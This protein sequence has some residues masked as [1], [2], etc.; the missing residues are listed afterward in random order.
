MKSI[1]LSGGSGTLG[2]SLSAYLSEKG[3]TVHI[4]TAD[5]GFV[6]TILFGK[7]STLLLNRSRIDITTL[8][9]NGYNLQFN[10]LG[11]ALSDIFYN[12]SGRV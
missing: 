4:L 6:L 3:Y 5:P 9:S 11:Q 8:L 1:L 2:K 12:T 7:M 10:N